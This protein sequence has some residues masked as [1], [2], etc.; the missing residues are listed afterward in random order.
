MAI[1]LQLYTPQRPSGRLPAR[2]FEAMLLASSTSATLHPGAGK[3]MEPGH[4]TFKTL[5]PASFSPCERGQLWKIDEHCIIIPGHDATHWR[6]CIGFPGIR[7]CSRMLCSFEGV[8]KEAHGFHSF[9]NWDSKS[10]IPI[11]LQPILTKYVIFQC[12]L[13][14]A[15]QVNYWSVQDCDC[16]WNVH[17]YFIGHPKTSLPSRAASLPL[18]DTVNGEAGQWLYRCGKLPTGRF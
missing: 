1:Y 4:W 9:L 17:G 7:W 18:E 13:M 10:T 16:L 2:S 15:H 5:N 12:T 3:V 6:F 14:L 11:H 8:F